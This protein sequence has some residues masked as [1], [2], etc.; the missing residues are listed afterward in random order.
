M[1]L[2]QLIVVLLLCVGYTQAQTL[3]DLSKMS[4]DDIKAVTYDQLGTL[5]VDDLKAI[6]TAKADLATARNGEVDAIQSLIDRMPGWS[7]KLVGTLGGNFAGFNNWISAGDANATTNSI[8]LDVFATAR[9]NDDKQ[10]L[11]NDLVA[12]VG[13]L[14]TDIDGSGGNDAVNT[15]APNRLNISSLYGYKIVKNLALSGNVTYNTALIGND[16][17]GNKVFNNP[18]DLDLGVGVTWTPITDFF[19]MVHPVNYHWKFGKNPDFASA[20][21]AKVKAGYARELIKGVSWISNLEGFYAYGDAGIN[22]VTMMNRPSASWYE[23]TNTFA[24]SV[25]KGIGVGLTYGIRR[26]DSEIQETQT[27]YNVGLSY[28]L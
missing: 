7:T 12:G 11:Y 14:S 25:W 18:G 19:L 3:G 28:T 15:T 27:R 21:G 10:F 4:S 26:A 17:L 24:F 13:R 23:W 16:A 22:E 9:Y 5:N 6:K 8:I 2:L 20:A 1:R